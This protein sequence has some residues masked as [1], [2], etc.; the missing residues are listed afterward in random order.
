[1]FKP[2]HASFAAAFLLLVPAGL[3]AQ[4]PQQSTPVTPKLQ[5]R[6]VIASAAGRGLRFAALGELLQLRLE[7]ISP[8]GEVVF[9][10]QFKAGNIIDWSAL[11]AQAQRPMDGA[12]L[13]IVTVKEADGEVT[14]RQALALTG[15]Q[16]VRL[17][18]IEKSLLA[19]AQAQAI[20]D[21]TAEEESMT[22]VNGEA[23]SAMAILAH[24]GQMAHLVSASGGLSISSGNFFAGRVLEQVRLTAEGNVGIGMSQPQVRLDVAGRI[25][26]S[27][28]IVFPD[29]SVQFS[30][31]RKTFGTASLRGGQSNATQEQ[32]A[33]APDIGGT[34][35]TGKLPKWQDGPN[36]I[37]NDSNLTG[38]REPKR[39]TRALILKGRERPSDTRSQSSFR[40]I[41]AV[42]R[43]D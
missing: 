39:S 6:Q 33:M 42:N 25:R 18:P 11:D 4:Q 29:G 26:A 40:P 16:S 2:S 23:A 38:V 24:D 30:A 28:G 8:T 20:A 15:E 19:P 34:G 9:D 32:D 14:K 43:I 17:R 7:V 31:S 22:L 13:C 41:S 27:E 21:S 1:M 35:T 36:G 37:L 3:L 5:P 10:S 12:Y